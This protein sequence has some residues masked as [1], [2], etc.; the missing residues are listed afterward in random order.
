MTMVLHMGFDYQIQVT[1]QVGDSGWILL[2]H[3]RDIHTIASNP[4]QDCG[5]WST[6]QVFALLAVGVPL[7][8]AA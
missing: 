4:L 5:D 8:R 3:N 1:H 2:A 7:C 6:L